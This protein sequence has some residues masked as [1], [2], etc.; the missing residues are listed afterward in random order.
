MMRFAALMIPAA[1][2]AACGSGGSPTEPPLQND[3]MVRSNAQQKL[4]ELND[5]DRAIALKRAIAD[6]GLRCSQIVSTGYV[7]RFRDMD[8]WT[9]TCSDDRQWALFI[10]AN[11][12]VQVRLCFDNEKVGLPACTVQPGTEGGTGLENM[13]TNKAG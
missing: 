10:G 13:V 11:D 2:L 12:S 1:M 8:M 6:Q 9:A 4:F 5:L 7:T 3:I